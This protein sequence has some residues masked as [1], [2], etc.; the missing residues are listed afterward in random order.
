MPRTHRH[1]YE[2]KFKV[3]TDIAAIPSIHQQLQ[4]AGFAPNLRCIE[5]D[6]LPD[7]TNDSLKRAKLLLR[8][9]QVDMADSHTLLLT[10][11][12]KQADND[13]LH[14]HEY[15]T[16][17]YQPDANIIAIINDLLHVQ[18][19][20]QLGEG[21]LA[22]STLEQAREAVTAL[23]LTK[24]RI[25]LSKYRE[26][27]S[28]GPDNAT[29][30]YFPD[31]MGVYVEFESHSAAALRRIVACAGFNLP[32]GTTTD[33]GDLLK[34]HKAGQTGQNQRTALFSPTEFA[35]LMEKARAV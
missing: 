21:V 9:R 30:D 1:E 2:L 28:L 14:F 20:V 12:A 17:L 18:T 26:H 4:T 3:G 35:E 10:L 27:F 23:G 11:K 5:T 24:H 8:F 16:D 31:G 29:I 34:L 6:Y 13:V 7:D 25:L 33:Y 22:A 15:E 32:A 19:G